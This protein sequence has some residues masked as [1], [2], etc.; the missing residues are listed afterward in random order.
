MKPYLWTNRFMKVWAIMNIA[1][2]FTSLWTNE[3][4]TLLFWGSAKMQFT[5]WG[6]TLI[7]S[8]IIV[9]MV[10]AGFKGWRWSLVFY[11]L[12]ILIA[13]P[14][15]LTAV[16][17]YWNNH[18]HLYLAVKVNAWVMTTAFLWSIL[19][20]ITWIIEAYRSK[21]KAKNNLNTSNG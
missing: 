4:P 10:I 5:L 11:A 19:C 12:L 16:V 3:I 2:F 21:H 8:S 18:M 7:T 15:E 1:L 20:I 9:F 6:V 17:L 14:D 13:A